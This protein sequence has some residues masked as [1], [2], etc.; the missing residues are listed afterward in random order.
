MIFEEV[1]SNTLTIKGC[2]IIKEP[3]RVS[4]PRVSFIQHMKGFLD[5]INQRAESGGYW[6]DPLK[7]G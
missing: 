1:K 4:G 5:E 2:Y 6:V 3:A 7:H